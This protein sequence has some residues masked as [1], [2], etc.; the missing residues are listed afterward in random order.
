MIAT[1]MSKRQ[2]LVVDSQLVQNGCVDVVDVE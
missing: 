2:P 1:T